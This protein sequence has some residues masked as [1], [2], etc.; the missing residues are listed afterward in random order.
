MVH[1]ISNHS[2]QGEIKVEINHFDLVA[3]SLKDIV[4][5]L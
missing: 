5:P 3:W 4:I 2:I 1:S